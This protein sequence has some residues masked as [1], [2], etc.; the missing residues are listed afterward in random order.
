MSSLF[1][2]RGSCAC[3]SSTEPLASTLSALHPV[4]APATYSSALACAS[5]ASSAATAFSSS[6]S[7]LPF[8]IDEPS[9]N[10]S[11]TSACS[12]RPGCD[13]RDDHGS[14]KKVGVETETTE[15][16]TED[17]LDFPGEWNVVTERLSYRH[18]CSGHYKKRVC[19]VW[20]C[21]GVVAH[22][23]RTYTSL[24]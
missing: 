3:D 11:K 8:S 6:E 13:D 20:P 24:V 10:A 15:T 1:T 4:D 2:S 21:G 23:K 22:S 19:Y 5:S 12:Q 9:S 7:F 16:E 14:E 18:T 17:E